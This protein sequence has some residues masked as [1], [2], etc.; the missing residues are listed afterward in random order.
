MLTATNPENSVVIAMLQPLSDNATTLKITSVQE[1]YNYE[2]FPP[3]AEKGC[4][5]FYQV[6]GDTLKWAGIKLQKPLIN[7]PT[8]Y[9]IKKI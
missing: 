7:R 2:V 6:N 1:N 5:E 8:I 9:I 3:F 4:E